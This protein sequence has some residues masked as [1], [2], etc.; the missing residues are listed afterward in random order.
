MDIIELIIKYNG[1]IDY[2]SKDIDVVIEKLSYGYAIIIIGIDEI[3]K[4][5]NYPEIEY[6]E[7]PR[8]LYF[9]VNEA[10]AV[11]CINEVQ[12]FN[13]VGNDSLNNSNNFINSA[14]SG[15]GVFFQ[16]SISSLSEG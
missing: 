14:L 2:I 13:M 1:D 5:K 11:S 4:L 6:I 15:E 9:F 8:R 10:K 16:F 7:E 12:Q 3:D